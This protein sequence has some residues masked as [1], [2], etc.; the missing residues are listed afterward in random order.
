MCSPGERRQLLEEAA[1]VRGV[2]ARRQEAAQRLAELAAEP[3]PARGPEVGD[4][5]PPRDASHSGGDRPR[6][7][8]GGAPGSRSCAAASCGRSGARRATPTAG[9][10]R[11]SSRSER[12]LVEA[13]ELAATRRREF[14]AGRSEMQ[15]AQ[16]RRLARQR[17][18]GELRLLLAD[19][20]H[21]L[22]A[23][24]GEGATT[25]ARWSRSCAQVGNRQL[26]PRA[27]RRRGLCST[28]WWSS[29][30]RPRPASRHCPRPIAA[31]R[32]RPIRRPCRT[33]RRAAEQARRAAGSPTSALAS[34]RTRREFLEEQLG[35]LEPLAA[36]AL[37]HP[38]GRAQPP[39]RWRKPSAAQAAATELAR[40]AAELDGLEALQVA[41]RRAGCRA[42]VTSSR[43]SRLR[44]C[45]GG[46]ART[47]GGCVCRARRGRCR[48]S[49][50]PAR[51]IRRRPWSTREPAAEVADRARWS[52]TS[53]VDAGYDDIARRLLGGVVVDRDVTRDGV[54]R[55]PGLVRA[56][57]DA[58][59]ELTVRRKWHFARGSSELGE[60]A[61]D[62][63]AAA[64]RG[65]TAPSAGW[66]SFAAQAAEAGRI[67]ETRRL[68]EAAFAAERAASGRLPALEEATA[69][70]EDVAVRLEGSWLPAPRRSASTAAAP[71]R[72]SPSARAGATGSTTSG[73]SFTRCGRTSSAMSHAA[74]DRA[75]RLGAAEAA[76][77]RGARV[78]ARASR[79]RWRRRAAQLGGVE[80][81]SPEEEAEMAEGAR[82]LV[83][84]EEARIDA[85]LKTGTLEGNLEL[86]A[87]EA[88]LLAARMEEIRARMP[89]GVAPEEIPG[90]K[91]REREMRAL[92]R[93]LEEIG[94]TNALADSE[95]RELE[96]RYRP[97]TSSSRTS[98]PPA[99]TSRPDRQ[100]ARGGGVALRSRVRRGRDELPRV[101]LAAC[102]RRSRDAAPRGGR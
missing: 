91:A 5:A 42:W 96:E 18:L 4:R 60:A 32:R 13:R 101:L 11:R 55:A 8:R 99:P 57:R 98:P 17:T 63:T 97:C 24:G 6:G 10:R 28:S 23:G 66:W 37:R 79:R 89:D 36:A 52:S 90:G 68:L 83:A 82:R 35:R 65:R 84:L 21:R 41:T 29:S 71:S 95:C 46:R 3:A 50:R 102:A 80:V 7:G 61:A 92:E 47:A 85:R 14:Q 51:A 44:G 53:N 77:V 27:R 64:E 69:E 54:Y 100:A 59:A 49:K 9:P 94:P 58:R 16:D 78:A 70:A 88:E 87:R 12:R 2:K 19:A 93:R 76:T 67:D 81:E 39:R 75:H 43:R 56:G 34:V 20:E 40:L 22:P 73:G 62:A 15:S 86:I 26:T 25:S 38:A 1:Q 30:S 74:E 72:S 33:A 48:A 31:A 45:A